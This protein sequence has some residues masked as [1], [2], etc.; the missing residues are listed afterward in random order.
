MITDDEDAKEVI[1]GMFI[2]CLCLIGLSN[3]TYLGLSNRIKKSTQSHESKVEK[4][5]KYHEKKKEGIAAM[6]SISQYA[7]ISKQSKLVVNIMGI[8]CS[9]LF[10]SI[11]QQRADSRIA[12]DLQIHENEQE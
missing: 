9:T 6:K 8:E 7:K 12:Q 2:A 4:V 5:E 3:L 11:Q 1:G 10:T